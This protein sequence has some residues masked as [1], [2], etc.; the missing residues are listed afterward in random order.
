MFAAGL[1]YAWSYQRSNSLLL[2]ILLHF[3]INL[4]HFSFFVYPAS[5][6]H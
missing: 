5:F 1:L 4:I 6:T 3:S 2:A